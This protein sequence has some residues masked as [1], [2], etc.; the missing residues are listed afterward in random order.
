[1]LA[2]V[3]SSVADAFYAGLYEDVLARTIDGRTFECP[4]EQTAFVVGALAFTGRLEE[5]RAVLAGQRRR[6]DAAR[7]E[8]L[9]ALVASKFFLGVAYSRAGRHGE[10]ERE[11]RENLRTAGRL[12]DP[13]CRFYVAQGLACLRYFRGLMQSATRH[14]RRSLRHAIDARFQYG[15]LLASDLRGHAL[16]HVGQVHAGLV[17]LERARDLGRALDLHGNAGA[18][19]CSLAVYRARFGV[20]PLRRAIEELDAL[21]RGTSAQD[22]YSR[23]GVVCELAQQLALAGRGDEAW[24]RLEAL[25]AT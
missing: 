21:T 16:V 23:R 1:M 6:G 5:A 22:S 18:I 20:A 10:A 8:H 15:R 17:L 7:V 9:R 2:D 14:V 24:A 25:S 12:E 13:L 11:F 19:E 3:S 4:E